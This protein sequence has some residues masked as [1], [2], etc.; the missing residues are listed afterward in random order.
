MW[1]RT[2]TVWQ[3]VGLG[4]MEWLSLMPKVWP[5]KLIANLALPTVMNAPDLP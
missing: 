2:G 4:I 1:I 5:S 3:T